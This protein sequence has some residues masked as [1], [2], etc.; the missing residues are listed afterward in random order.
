VRVHSF[1]RLALWLPII[2]P[3]IVAGLVHGAG[4][5]VHEGPLRTVVQILLMSLI[6]GGVPYALLAVWATWW[7]GHRSEADI[8]GLISRAPLLMGALYV[9]FAAFVGLA[10]GQPLMFLMVGV[11]GGDREHSSRLR[12]CRIRDAGAGRGL[13]PTRVT[14]QSWRQSGLM[15][16]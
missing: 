2:V 4:L 15:Y 8:K 12:I 3:A 9:L 10:V 14:C 5:M 11:I 1:Y 6:Y 7:I 16:R 13:A